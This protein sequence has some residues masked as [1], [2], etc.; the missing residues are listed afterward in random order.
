MQLA[1]IVDAWQAVRATRSRKQKVAVLSEVLRRLPP[2]ELAAGTAMLAGEARQGRIGVGYAA[3]QQVEAAPATSSTLTVTEV[4]RALGDLQATSGP[5]SVTRRRQLLDDLFARATDAEQDYLRG[6]ILANLRQGALEGIVVEAVAA[7]TGIDAD[8]IRRAAMLSGDLTEAAVAATTGGDQAIA[9]FRLRLLRPVQPMLAQS[10]NTVADALATTGRALVDTKLDGMRIQAHRD[11]DDVRVFTRNLRDVTGGMPA[12]AAAVRALSVDRVVLDGEA[13]ALDPD[14]RAV[15]FQ[16]SMQADAALRPW[17]FDVLHADGRDLLDEPLATRLEVLDELVPEA[18]RVPRVV[19]DDPAVGHAWFVDAV[20]EGFEGVV[21]KAMD[22]PY[23]AGRRGAS[24]VKV[25]P[26]HTLDLVVL[27]VEWGSGRRQGL[28]SNLHLGA[29]DPV[30]GGFVMLGKTFKGLTDDLLAWQTE[31][32]LAREVRREGHVVHVRP[33]LVVE[34]AFDG[35]QTS[36]R[37]PGGMALRFARVKRYRLDKDPTDADTIDTVR[38]IHR[39]DV[40]P[41]TISERPPT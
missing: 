22:A 20:R 17:F 12:V 26:N 32:L 3:I 5:G 33:E 19:T 13:M 36:R 21:V 6:L 29:Y 16:E 38:A 7:A 23:E 34:I 2:E 27:A 41:V 35:V 18:L 8:R 28:L 25:K 24:W 10:A 31:Q 11:G 30:E 9:A 4:D 39:G 40:L 37:Y 15:A 1:E 14:G